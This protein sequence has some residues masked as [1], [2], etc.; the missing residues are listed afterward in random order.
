MIVPERLDQF[1]QEDVQE[2]V[3]EAL[4]LYAGPAIMGFD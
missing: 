4:E 1:E 3:R 2:L